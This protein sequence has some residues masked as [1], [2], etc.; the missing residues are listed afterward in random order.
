MNETWEI[1]YPGAGA[2]GLPFARSQ[3]GADVAGERVLIHAAPPAVSVVVRDET[4]VPRASGELLERSSG[5][6]MSCLRREGDRVTLDDLWPGPDELG[7]LVL[8]AG[9][10]AGIL[11]S[12]WHADDHSEWRW[13]LEFYNHT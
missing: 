2:T 9:G 4:G 6:P 8:L 11:R 10:E 1:W 12:W 13:E 7:L 3:V 5:G